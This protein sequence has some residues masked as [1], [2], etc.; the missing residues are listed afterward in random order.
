MPTRI[1]ATSLALLAFAIAIA[2]GLLA[3]NPPQQILWRALV[4]LVTCYGVG[5]VVG[6][7]AQRA[8]DEHLEARRAAM[9]EAHE[10]RRRAAA[11]ESGTEPGV[12]D[13]TASD[14]EAAEGNEASVPGVGAAVPV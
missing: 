9:E 14:A 4:C 13:N 5:A 10:A 8:M 2:A 7:V 11:D 6:A 1:I 3:Q 12:V